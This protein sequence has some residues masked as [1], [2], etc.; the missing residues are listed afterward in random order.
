MDVRTQLSQLSPEA[1]E[2]LAHKIKGRLSDDGAAAA[3]IA[4]R[5]AIDARHQAEPLLQGDKGGG[6]PSG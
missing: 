3:E 6:M 1:R 4:D 2:A 5:D